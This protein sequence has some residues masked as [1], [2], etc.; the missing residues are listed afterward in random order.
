MVDL[1]AFPITRKWPARRTA[2]IQ[3]YSLNTPNGVKAS[4]LLEE[5]GLPYE[6]HLVNFDTNDQN[7]PEFLSLN[8]NN[9]IPAIIDPQGP[10]GVPL[11]LFESCAIL[12][13]LADKSGRFTPRDAA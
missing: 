2:R 6:S 3:L 11:P 12:L 1:S 4:I 8:P 13:Y 5:T 10:G 9:K 7:S